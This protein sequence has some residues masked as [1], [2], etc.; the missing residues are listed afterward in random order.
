MIPWWGW[1]LI[2]M[3]VIMPLIWAGV[4]LVS[5]SMIH[6]DQPPRVVT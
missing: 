2:F 1:L 6:V 5:A 4:F 3:F